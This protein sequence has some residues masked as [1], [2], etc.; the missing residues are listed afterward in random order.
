MRATIC[1]TSSGLICDLKSHLDV[2][3]KTD[4]IV[5]VQAA[6]DALQLLARQHLDFECAKK[7]GHWQKPAFVRR[8]ACVAPIS[9]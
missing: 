9:R 2:A 5:W 4:D 8:C 3:G 7:G 6:A 1:K